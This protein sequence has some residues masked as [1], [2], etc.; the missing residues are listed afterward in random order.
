MQPHLLYGRP[1]L[2]LAPAPRLPRLVRRRGHL[3]HDPRLRPPPHGARGPRHRP[4]V[5]ELLVPEASPHTRRRDFD[6]TPPAQLL[7]TACFKSEGDFRFSLAR[8]REHAESVAFYGGARAEA[9]HTVGLLYRLAGAL[10]ERI[11]CER[12]LTMFGAKTPRSAMPCVCHAA[13]SSIY[14]GSSTHT[15]CNS[16]RSRAQ[17][18]FTTI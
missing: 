14:N 12:K 16:T 9:S 11:A 2:H 5:P 13:V 17:W 3:R 8:M 10:F 18:N 15:D 4:C 1:L 6:A 7:N